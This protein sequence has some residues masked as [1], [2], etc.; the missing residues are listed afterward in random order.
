MAMKTVKE[1]KK[2]TNHPSKVSSF[3]G[4]NLKV[5]PAI[6]QG[7]HYDVDT[8]VKTQLIIY[9]SFNQNDI[10]IFDIPVVDSLQQQNVLL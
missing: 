2:R 5:H 4:A 6:V 9:C 3:Y 8:A 10:W 7:D 1:G